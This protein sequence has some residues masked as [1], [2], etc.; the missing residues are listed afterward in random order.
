MTDSRFCYHFRSAVHL[1]VFANR[2]D[3][4]TDTAGPVV[5]L[6]DLYMVFRTGHFIHLVNAAFT[7][8]KTM[9]WTVFQAFPV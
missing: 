2:A 4:S 8:L 3:I 7:F 6:P 9:G 1:P 5:F